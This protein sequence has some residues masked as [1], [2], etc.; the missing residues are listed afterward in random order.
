MINVLLSFLLLTIHIGLNRIHYLSCN[1]TGS[2]QTE[3]KLDNSWNI[4]FTARAPT[5]RE[6]WMDV[7]IKQKQRLNRARRLRRL[8]KHHGIH[9][10]P[11]H[12]GSPMMAAANRWRLVS[13]H[14]T[15]TDTEGVLGR[16][17]L[18][19]QTYGLNFGEM[20]TV[21]SR[22]AAKATKCFSNEIDIG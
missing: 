15:H 8:C 22:A 14:Q 21:N 10:W 1:Y 12:H 3:Q 6:K 2:I 11:C 16:L 4:W 19:R 9:R 20:R 13:L 18:I 17:V 7:S 5:S